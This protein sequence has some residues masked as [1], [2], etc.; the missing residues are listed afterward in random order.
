MLL[1]ILDIIIVSSTRVSISRAPAPPD[2]VFVLLEAGLAFRGGPQRLVH[3]ISSFLDLLM[4]FSMPRCGRQ[5]LSN[6]PE[7]T[8]RVKATAFEKVYSID[9]D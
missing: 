3:R 2:V 9:I 1:E 7:D 6:D 8:K 5:T 4:D